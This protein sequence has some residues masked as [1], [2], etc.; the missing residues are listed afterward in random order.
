MLE[1]QSETEAPSVLMR[2]LLKMHNYELEPEFSKLSEFYPFTHLGLQYSP[3]FKPSLNESQAPY[4]SA[5]SIALAGVN[6]ET[7]KMCVVKKCVRDLK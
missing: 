2:F 6:D 4:L 5:L 3:F 7:Q 1:S